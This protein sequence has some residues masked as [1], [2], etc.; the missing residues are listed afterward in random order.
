MTGI[1][2]PTGP[3]HHSY[4]TTVGEALRRAAGHL[5]RHGWTRDHLLYDAHD[6]CQRR[7]QCHHTG[8]YPASVLG[9]IR[10]AVCGGPRWFLHPA[11]TPPGLVGAYAAVVDALADHLEGF[12]DAGL[13]GSIWLWQQH[14]GRSLQEVVAALHAAA[15]TAPC[16]PLLIV[17]QPLAPVIDL[18]SRSTPRVGQVG[19]RERL[20][21]LTA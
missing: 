3:S 9:A 4:P 17:E 2:G 21:D 14:P 5:A 10:I 18:A 12:G 7:C 6:R 19:D 13:R 20:F 15:S 8:R 11:T 16:T 1:A